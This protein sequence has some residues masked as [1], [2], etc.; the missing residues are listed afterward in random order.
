MKR[1]DFAQAVFDRLP[2][3]RPGNNGHEILAALAGEIAEVILALAPAEVDE[4]EKA[5]RYS[6]SAGETREEG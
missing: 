3:K 4:T 5:V 1:D 6:G 2:T